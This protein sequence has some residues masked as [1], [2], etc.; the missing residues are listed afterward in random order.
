MSSP[1]IW[2]GNNT[3]T[4]LQAGFV[5][6]GGSSAGIFT[7]SVDPSLIATFGNPGSLYQSSSGRVFIKN[8]SGTTTNW[9]AI[10]SAGNAVMVASSSTTSIPNGSA[11]DIIYSSVIKDTYSGYNPSTGVFT[12]PSGQA[13]DFIVTGCWYSGTNFPS[14]IAGR[15][16]TAHIYVNGTIHSSGVSLVQ[17]STV[18]DQIQAR[19]VALV[20]NLSAGDTVKIVGYQDINSSTAAVL[21]GGAN[22]NYF[23]LFRI[24]GSAS[25][26]GSSSNVILSAS[27]G[28]VSFGGGGPSADSNLTLTITT[29]GN[30][31][32]LSL[33]QDGS[34]NNAYIGL[35]AN[36]AGQF[37]IY[38][39]GSAITAQGINNPSSTGV[40]TMPSGAVNYIDTPA[41]GT[42]TYQI[43]RINATGNLLYGYVK[44][45]AYELSSGSSGGGGGSSGITRSILNISTNTTAAAAV[46]TDYVYNVSGTTTL[47][48]PTAVGNTNR[49]TVK[50]DGVSTVTVNFTSGQTAD[51]SSSVALTRA[52]MS[53]D[54][55][56]NGTNWEI[57]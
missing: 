15:Q 55:I 7:G 16:F 2:G 6:G 13:G 25:L 29:T 56:S 21:S 9:S 11:T 49:Y 34:G 36:A 53:L 12:V 4:N 1:F 42:Y 28:V 5:Q 31:V 22:V 18:S 54:F 30:P 51:G 52:N 14:A 19:V 33:V 17:N 3:S 44:L 20:P 32:I 38:R 46:R 48:L 50:N 43:Y 39:N 8:D 23:S 35:D 40:L 45:A 10:N 41:A 27:S 57:N 26:S 37:L 47:T 24:G